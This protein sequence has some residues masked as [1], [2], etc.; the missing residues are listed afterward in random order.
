MF[1]FNSITQENHPKGGSAGNI[2][3]GV[4]GCVDVG[5]LGGYVVHGI[6]GRRLGL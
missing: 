3:D 4:G 1:F 2:V 5:K 6:V